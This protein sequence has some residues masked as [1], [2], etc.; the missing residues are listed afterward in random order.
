MS[1]TS[2]MQQKVTNVDLFCQIAERKGHQVKRAKNGELLTVEH[3][4]GYNTTNNVSDAVAEVKLKDWRYPL[5]IRSNGEVL[6]DHFGSKPQS[7]AT[8]HE[9]MQDYNQE[10][11]T[12]NIPYDQLSNWSTKKVANGDVVIT[13]EY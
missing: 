11:I 12:S 5:A 2:T 4:H 13:L 6:Y 9:V 7:M 1:H 10:L 3:Y 8:F